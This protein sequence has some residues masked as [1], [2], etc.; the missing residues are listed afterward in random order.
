MHRRISHSIRCPLR[1]QDARY[2]LQLIT[3]QRPSKNGLSGH[4]HGAPACGRTGR[5]ARTALS[6]PVALEGQSESVASVSH[7]CMAVIC[8][9]NSTVRRALWTLAWYDE[10]TDACKR[11]M[12]AR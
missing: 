8:A 10:R 2:D 3:A 1:L 6:L 9:W 7:S 4:A 12:V 11:R 5:I